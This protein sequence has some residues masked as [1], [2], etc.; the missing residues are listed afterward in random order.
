MSGMATMIQSEQICEVI[1]NEPMSRHT[2]WRAGGC[3]RHYAI[4]RTLE[5]LQQLMV[6]LP[7]SEKIEWMGLGSNT[8]VR[9]G[10]FNGT[11]VATQ[12]MM[13]KIKQLNSQTLYIG[14]GVPDAKLARF[15]TQ[16]GMHEAAFFAGIPGLFGGALAMNAGAWGGETWTHVISVETM[17]R[18]GEIQQR[19]RDEFDISYRQVGKHHGEWFV[20]AIMHFKVSDNSQ[21]VINSKQLLAERARLQP[22]GVASCGSVFRNPEADYAARLIEQ[23]GLKGTRIGGAVVSGKHANFI[24]N[25]N[26][27]SASDIEL[28]IEQIRQMVKQ[29][30]GILLQPE[31][32]IIGEKNW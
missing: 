15:C 5:Q 9:D 18:K 21:G 20:G 30:R 31:V 28:L 3:A 27:A 16:R 10:G 6:L 4:P 22:T 1:E 11:I 13:N 29:Q 23:C 17:N 14:A 8:L 24:I 32:K 12:H 25:D 2:S 19:Q 7:A 26:N